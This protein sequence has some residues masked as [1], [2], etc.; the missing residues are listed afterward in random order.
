MQ[1]FSH[2]LGS[3]RTLAAGRPHSTNVCTT[4]TQFPKLR[5]SYLPPLTGPIGDPDL[6]YAIIVGNDPKT[7]TTAAGY[8][9]SK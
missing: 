2:Q 1:T 7:I 5:V 8:E 3:L 9:R 6:H 4:D